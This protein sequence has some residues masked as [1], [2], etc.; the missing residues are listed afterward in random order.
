MEV[1]AQ[2]P[3]RIHPDLPELASLPTPC[4][5]VDAAATARNVARL[6]EAARAAGMGLRPHAKSHK[7][8]EIARAQV[9]AGARGLCCATIQEMEA[10]HAAGLPGL[11]LTAPQGEARVFARLAALDRRAPVLAVVDHPDQSA[12]AAAACAPGDPPLG[13]LVD[14]DVG[15]A[16]TGVAGPAEAVALARRIAATPGLRFAGL[17][18][19]AGH[20]QHTE[21]Q[22]DR[23]AASAA[24]SAR[25]RAALAALDEAGLR[26][27]IV[28]GGGTGAL[29]LDLAEGLLGEV[30]AGSYVFMDADYARIRQDPPRPFELALHVLATVVSTGPGGRA[31]LNAGTKSMATNG[32]AP[33]VIL[34]APPGTRFAFG[35]DEQAAL[36]LPPGA[37]PARIGQRI[38]MAT[39][40]CD[41]SVNLHARLWA[42]RAGEAPTPWAVVGRDRD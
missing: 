2:S 24:A 33:Q 1:A 7:C 32:P 28:T 37:P 34:G 14:L 27:G 36:T 18:A 11:L 40:H 41:P 4:L 35:G 26:P 9:A 38:L 5:V 10:L 6:A 25:L 39:P 42:W 22:E 15:F 16:R 31:T 13:L 20:V 8:V 30:Q 12:M 29:E 21:A 23:A 19:Y 3:G 17:Q